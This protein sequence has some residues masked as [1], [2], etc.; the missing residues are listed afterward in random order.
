M[1]ATYLDEL[2]KEQRT[3]VETTSGPLLILAGA[4][5]GKTKTLTHRILHLIHC[6]VTPENILAITFTNKAAREMRDRL[7]RLIADDVSLNTP[8]THTTFPFASTFHALG[9]HILRANSDKLPVTRSFSIL[10]RDDALKIVKDATLQAG[11]DPKEHA[12][13]K[14]LSV[15]SKEKGK[16]NTAQEFQ[17][18]R[19]G[20]YSGAIIGDI[21]VRYEKIKTDQNSLDF[22]D[23]LVLTAFLLRKHEDVRA[24]YRNKWTHIHIDEYQDTNEVQNEIASLLTGIDNDICAVGDIDQNIYSWRGAQIRHIL[25]FEKTFPNTKL[26]VLEQNYRSTQNILRA[27][28][29]IIEKNIHRKEKKLFTQNAEGDKLTLYPATT[30][31]DEARFVASTARDLIAS[32]VD[33]NDIVVLYRANF[34]SRVLEEAFLHYDVPYQVLGVRFFERK[35]I[36]D[37]M[38]FIRLA[39]NPENI[40][41]LNR[42]INV[43]PRGI[44]K[45]TLGRIVNKQ[46]TEL[47]PAMQERVNDFRAMLQRIK[48][49]SEKE[50]TSELVRFVMQETG[51]SS[52]LKRE[53][54]EGLEKL[55]NLRE[56]VTLATKYDT[57]E[58]QEGVEKLMEEASLATDQD[59]LNQ[60]KDGVKLMT[61]HASKGLEF[62]YVFVTGLEEGLF[63][64]K[65]FDTD[66]MT[67]EEAEEERRLFYVALTRAKKKLYLTYAQVRTIFGSQEIN[68]PSE[69][70]TDIDDELFDDES[71]ESGT[72]WRDG[73]GLLGWPTDRGISG[74]DEPSIAF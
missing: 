4:G 29:Q 26:V 41:D 61:V 21:W 45:V 50:K 66:N 57:L 25:D 60:P 43:P 62:S 23:L 49:F 24:H 30:E 51:I 71:V 19:A 39:L 2:N 65:K 68:M 73:E 37:V 6:G 17:S 34:Q 32:G 54:E 33:S 69:F 58:P 42:V 52:V 22:D 10:D 56:L 47:T 14:V 59:S 3:A 28:N 64:H 55:E 40:S 36:K 38:A 35:E 27:A 11:Y 7:E 1:N 9:V 8:I 16:N 67:A 53:G 13:A 48:A 12:P 44:G 74:D 72:S 63:P 18:A 5:A 70:I 31:N 46:E 15:I 20:Q